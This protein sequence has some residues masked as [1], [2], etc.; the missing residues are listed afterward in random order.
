[1]AVDHRSPGRADPASPSSRIKA[2][3]A[4]LVVAVVW[5]SAFSAQRVVAAHVGF[6]LFNGLRFLLGALT[7]LPLVWGRWRAPDRFESR[8]TEWRGGLLA[9]LLLA[10]ASALQQAGLRFTTA[11][12]AGF[13]T[14]LY[15]VLVPLFLAVGW[16]QWPRPAAW[17]ASLLA[18]TGLFLLSAE[19]SLALSLGDGLEVAG[20]A[21]WALHL[22]LI[23][24]LA[25]HADSLRLAWVQYVACG[26]LSTALG[27]GLEAH[28][29]PGLASAW[30][31]VIYGGVLSVGL[32]FTLQVVGQ[33]VAPAADAALILSLE[34]VFA[35]L[36][37]WLL[38]GEALSVRQVAGCAL[39]LCGVV[40][41]QLPVRNPLTAANR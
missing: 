37:G 34:A 21:L 20:A 27:L 30:W 36:F 9:G 16:R 24:R 11:G 8:R 18:A 7:L 23:G 39:M 14:S 2:D 17:A 19:R 15:V 28:T 38:L 40:L 12:K 10:S 6:F 22:I 4:L 1:L 32:G 25:N 26:L 33:K 3:L 13:I 35:A 31:A 5:G 29:L 41:A